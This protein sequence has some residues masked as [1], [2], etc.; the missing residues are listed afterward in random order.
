MEII[1]RARYDGNY[2][3]A[4]LPIRPIHPGGN[5]GWGWG[6]GIRG[7]NLSDLH[8]LSSLRDTR[9]RSRLCP[10]NVLVIS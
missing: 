6:G 4:R 9:R 7:L 8:R 2:L 5:D 3:A 1:S 10:A